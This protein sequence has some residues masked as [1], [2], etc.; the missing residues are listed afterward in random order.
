[1]GLNGGSPKDADRKRIAEIFS[2]PDLIWRKVFIRIKLKQQ[3]QEY[4]KQKIINIL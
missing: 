2:L 4:Y 3:R 1:M